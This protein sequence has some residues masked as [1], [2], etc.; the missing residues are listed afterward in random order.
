LITQAYSTYNKGTAAIAIGII[1]TI[2]TFFPDS[3]IT[4]VSP[5][6]VEE[7]R[8]YSKYGVKNYER[9]LNIAPQRHRGSK[10]ILAFGEL[11]LKGLIYL[12]NAKIG[13]RFPLNPKTKF[14]LELFRKTDIV[15]IGGGGMFGG[16]KFRSIAG[17][18]FPIL[19]AKQFG[20][21]VIIYA[22]T[23]EPFTS[24]IVKL[25]TKFA[26]NKADI[27]TVREQYTFNLLKSLG[28][29]RPFYMTAD[30]A[31]LV[32]HES[33]DRGLELLH[34]FGV[35]GNKKLRI[36]MTIRDFDFPG[37]PNGDGIR[38]QYLRAI[39]SAIERI[40]SETDWEIIVF[41]TS[42]NTDFGDDDRTISVKIRESI[43]ENLRNR[44]FVL[45]DD[46]TP[47]ETKAM[48]GNTDVFVATRTHSGIFA[49]TMNVP[50]LNIACEPHKNHGIMEI[51]GLGNYVLDAS[52]ISADTLVAAIYKMVNERDLIG[53]KIK[54]RLPAVRN[55]SLENGKFLLSLL[56][57]NYV[58]DSVARASTLERSEAPALSSKIK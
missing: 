37:E 43:S 25:A 26:F 24:K 8:H 57:L 22:P 5:A 3:E 30:P 9:L 49:F 48:I 56:N 50:L 13:G 47:E 52:N 38:L 21:K 35:S 4:I 2:R 53:E 7:A 55:K 29:K 31:F 18:L 46:Y 12:L 58:T 23:V 1:N 42:I 27:I 15:I 39:S 16:N 28:I 19:L 34:L 45:T 17:N 20:K 10:K 36:G 41:T 32:D 33:L 40:L 14:V 54:E 44:I 51:M 11:I 6:P